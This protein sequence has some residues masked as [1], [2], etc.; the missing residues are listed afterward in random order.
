[1]ADPPIPYPRRHR[2]RLLL[3][4]LARAAFAILTRFEAIGVDRIPDRGP[5][6]IVGNHFHFA[7]PV[8]LVPY[9]PWHT[10]YIG[11]AVMPDAPP[12]L[13]WIPGLWGFLPVHRGTA[14]QDA[15]K[16]ARH[17]RD[18]DGIL[19]VF[20][21]AG[22]WAPVLRPARPGAAFLAAETGAPLLP[23]GLDGLIDIFPTLRR[24][25]RC[26]V[27]LRV[28]EPC[29][30]FR[31]RGRGRARRQELEAIGEEIMR[32]IAALIP[33]AR[34]GVFS[35][36]PVLRAAAEDVAAYPWA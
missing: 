24:G 16:A 6:I 33:A 8:A 11:G 27:T 7:D 12:A 31:T 13:T 1:M 22:S 28:G 2:R 17:V 19:V 25:G 21:E 20:P 18:R 34:H 32:Q 26:R 10:E 14:T 29:G 23:I 15:L 30:P 4:R 5:L 36:D 9:I 35:D 3:R